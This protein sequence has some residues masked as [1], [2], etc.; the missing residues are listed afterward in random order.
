M[1]QI[2]AKF[3]VAHREDDLIIAQHFYQLWLDNQ[4]PENVIIPDWQQELIKFIE[5]ARS[6]LDYQAFVAEFDGKPIGSVSCQLFAGLYP[7]P[8]VESYRKYGY[9]WGVYVEPEYRQQGIGTQLTQRAVNYLKSINCTQVILHASPYGMPVYTKLGF[10]PSNE[11]R[12]DLE[13]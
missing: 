3:R 6:Q 7:I 10:V 8:F 4:V 11:M 1:G 9:I 13:V 5:S 2:E 12:L